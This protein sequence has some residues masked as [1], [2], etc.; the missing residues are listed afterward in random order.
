MTISSTPEPTPEPPAKPTGLITGASH[1]SGLLSWTNPDDDSITGYQ[2]LRG[3][4]AGVPCAGL[5]ISRAKH[6][7][8]RKCAKLNQ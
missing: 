6:Q 3:P 4:D 2:V 1:N 5:L 8:T 7:P